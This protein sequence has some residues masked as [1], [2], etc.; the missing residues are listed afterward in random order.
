MQRLFKRLGSKSRGLTVWL[1]L[2]GLSLTAMAPMADAQSG[3]RAGK[4]GLGFELGEPTGFN[5]KYWLD[6]RNAL[7]FVVGWNSWGYRGRDYYRDNRCYDG[8]FRN[9]TWPYCR[10]RELDG[11]RWDQFHFHFD[12]LAHR[13]DIIRAQIPIPIYYGGGVQYEYRNY[14][15]D[16]SWLGVRGTAGIAL[17]PKTIPFD[18][19]FELAPVFYVLPGPDFNLNGGIGARFWF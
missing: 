13:F 4:F 6:N 9:S 12:Y 7:D 3:N 18:F 8:N 2:L 10:D 11:Y 15:P 19:F 5:A 14:W 16:Q 17:M 1:C